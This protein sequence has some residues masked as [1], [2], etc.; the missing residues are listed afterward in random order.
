MAEG[1][2]VPIPNLLFVSSQKRFVLSSVG[3]PVTESAKN[4]E[5]VVPV[6]VKESGLT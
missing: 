5:P 1:V 2:F 3:A 6:C 4:S